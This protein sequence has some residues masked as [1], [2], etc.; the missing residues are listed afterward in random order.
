[1]VP[2]IPRRALVDQAN[3]LMESIQITRQGGKP[4]QGEDTLVGLLTNTHAI[5]VAR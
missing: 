3:A 2:V 1:M 5:K 4:V